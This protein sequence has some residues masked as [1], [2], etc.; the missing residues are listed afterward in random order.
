MGYAFKRGVT[1]L[2]LMIVVAIV[3]IMAG[4]AAM[5]FTEMRAI[6]SAREETR[7]LLGALRNARTLS[8]ATTVP[9]GIY[10]GGGNDAINPDLRNRV[11][12]FRKATPDMPA[13]DYAA[14]DY[15]LTQRALPAVGGTTESMILFDAIQTNSN[16][17]IRVIF[18]RNGNP[19][20]WN[21]IAGVSTPVVITPGAP[22]VL[23]IR[24]RGLEAKSPGVTNPSGRCIEMVQNGN[25]RIFDA[26]GAGGCW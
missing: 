19:Q 13:T 24:H 16:S 4:L 10:I 17:S 11:A 21:V 22:A 15:I 1:I 8:V 9:H 6:G 18:D 14:G 7:F 23:G 25:T 12:M 3:G 20:I 26:A 5:S 2:E